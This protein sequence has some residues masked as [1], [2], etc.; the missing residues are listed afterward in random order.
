M[1]DLFP[2]FDVF[3]PQNCSFNLSR[4]SGLSAGQYIPMLEFTI[5]ILRSKVKPHIA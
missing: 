2:G 5:W 4:E 3:V 1:A